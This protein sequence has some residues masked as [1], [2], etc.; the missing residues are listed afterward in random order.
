MRVQTN[1]LLEQLAEHVSKPDVTSFLKRR[2][3]VKE[4]SLSLYLKE[5][6]TLGVPSGKFQII[7]S[8]KFIYL[9]TDKYQG[10]LVKET[11]DLTFIS[12]CLCCSTLLI[13]EA[14]HLLLLIL[15]QTVPFWKLIKV[16]CSG[17]GRSKRG[18]YSP[19]LPFK[20][21]SFL[22]MKFKA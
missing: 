5:L 4:L 19:A 20:P 6:R 15:S 22:S 10:S 17:L 18:R 9:F 21:S 16:F 11:C 7:N 1:T 3:I 13:A 12:F 14:R 2:F 8:V